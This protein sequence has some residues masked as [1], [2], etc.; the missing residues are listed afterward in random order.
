MRRKGNTEAFSNNGHV[1]DSFERFGG[2][3][4][5]EITTKIV[6]AMDYVRV[7][8]FTSGVSSSFTH[9]KVDL[10]HSSELCAEVL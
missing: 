5:L 2:T 8:C 7:I 1:G 9:W 10:F 6:N 3:F 4:Q